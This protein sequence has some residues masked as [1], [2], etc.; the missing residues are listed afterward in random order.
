MRHV[1]L[2]DSFN[3]ARRMSWVRANRDKFYLADLSLTADIPENPEVNGSAIAARSGWVTTRPGV[4]GDP[5]SVPVG[6]SFS[7]GG[8]R[9]SRID[10]APLSSQS[11]G[12][13]LVR[14]AQGQIAHAT[15]RIL[16]GM[17]LPLIRITG[18]G[19]VSLDV[20]R[21]LTAIAVSLSSEK[22]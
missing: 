4:E 2:V 17:A 14:D 7:H 1:R 16:S 6:V 19:W 9:F 20:A 5:S 15:V 22:V 11:A 3:L 12:D 8:R 13:W 21:A 10:D 18:Q